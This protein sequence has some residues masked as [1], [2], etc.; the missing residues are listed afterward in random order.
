MTKYRW[1]PE[2]MSFR[3]QAEGRWHLEAAC[4]KGLLVIQVMTYLSFR[5]WAGCRWN[6]EFMSFRSQA[7]GRWHLEAAHKKGLPII[8]VMS[9]LSFRSWAE[10][11]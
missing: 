7:E 5:S 3:S 10:C 2:V 1:N 11:R 4:K 6:P 9:Y 8:Q